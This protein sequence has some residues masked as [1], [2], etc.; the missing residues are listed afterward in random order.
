MT[1]LHHASQ[2]G[3]ERVV[4]TLVE[5]GVGIHEKDNTYPPHHL[6]VFHV[7]TIIMNLGE[8]TSLHYA[9]KNGHESVVRTLVEF[10]VF[11]HE[12]DNTYPHTIYT[13]Y[14]YSLS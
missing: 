2:K 12:K 3:H 9:S 7:L 1:S 13:C 11:I 10:G 5:F 8:M 4:R 14:M 6:Y